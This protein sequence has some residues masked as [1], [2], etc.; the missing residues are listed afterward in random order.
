MENASKALL[1][2]GGILIALLVIGAL[3]LMFNQISTYQQSETSNEKNTQLAKFNM[4]FERYLDDSGISGADIV[5]LANKI[6]DYNNKENTTHNVANSVDYS[7]KMSLTVSNMESFRNRYAYTAAETPIF[8]ENKYTIS[9][10]SGNENSFKNALDIYNN[11]NTNKEL[12]KKVSS[13]YSLYNNYNDR[14]KKIKEALLEINDSLYNDWRLNGT[15]SPTEKQIK[16]YKEYTEFKTSTFVLS[17]DPEYENGQIKN[18]YF[19]WKN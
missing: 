19:K 4:D 1:M 17:Q 16:N 12:L 8:E 10:D 6:V 13:I 14:E 2:A 11:T 5:T 7:I 3:L 18:L 15:Q 9:V